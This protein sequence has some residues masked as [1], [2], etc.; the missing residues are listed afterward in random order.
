MSTLCKRLSHRRIQVRRIQVDSTTRQA[1]GDDLSNTNALVLQIICQ[2]AFASGRR[3]KWG[4][5]AWVPHR[6]IPLTN[7]LGFWL[8]D[9]L[10]R[11]GM[12]RRRWWR[13]TFR[14]WRDRLLERHDSI[15]SD[16][17]PDL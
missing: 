8:S 1:V 14:S 12:L 4:H 7:R 3:N 10:G 17:V 5:K 11:Y 6:P 2:L 15:A 9:R 16:W 13:N